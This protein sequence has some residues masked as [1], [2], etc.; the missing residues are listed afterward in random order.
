MGKN[1]G[2]SLKTFGEKNLK[3]ILKRPL[4]SFKTCPLVSEIFG[5]LQKSFEIL[6]CFSVEKVCEIFTGFEVF[7][8]A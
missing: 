6:M 5:E 4:K 7:T 3:I 8:R 1:C 2:K